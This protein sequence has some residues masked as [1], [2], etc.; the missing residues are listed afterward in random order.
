MAISKSDQQLLLPINQQVPLRNTVR[1]GVRSC[2]ASSKSQDEVGISPLQH[3]DL[4]V[5]RIPEHFCDGVVG[6]NVEGAVG[7]VLC[8]NRGIG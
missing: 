3:S 1:V 6:I 2:P 4:N 7:D 5:H 8:T